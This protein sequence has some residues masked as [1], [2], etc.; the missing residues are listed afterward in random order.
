MLF[1]EL[2]TKYR[3]LRGM[4]VKDLSYAAQVDERTIRRI[5]SGQDGMKASAQ[6]RLC[7]VL[8]VD[9][10]AAMQWLR[11]DQSDASS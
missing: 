8:G 9:A 11:P 6:V 10:V 3:Q 5:E 2:V 7:T 1:S 4:S